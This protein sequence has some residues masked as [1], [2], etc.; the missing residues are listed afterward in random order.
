MPE[1]GKGRSGQ[2]QYRQE[3]CSTGEQPAYSSELRCLATCRMCHSCRFRLEWT[4]P[5]SGSLRQLTSWVVQGGCAV[6]GT[7]AK[8]EHR[9]HGL[10]ELFELDRGGL[11]LQ[12]NVVGVLG[13]A[14]M[15]QRDTTHPLL[16][17]M[18]LTDSCARTVMRVI[19]SGR[20]DR[21][22]HAVCHPCVPTLFCVINKH[23]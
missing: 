2:D 22:I 12:E 15:V 1:S 3:V 17:V 11:G 14:S 10:V 21:S 13:A 18:L 5:R 16:R 20:M 19:C 9:M 4:F 8:S 7:H 6:G 23:E